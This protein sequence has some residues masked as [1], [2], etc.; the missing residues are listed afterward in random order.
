MRLHVGALAITLALL[1]GCATTVE[2]VAE[3]PSGREQ[4][5]LIER[6]AVVAALDQDRRLVAL[7]S[8]DG[9]I[10]VI[11]VAEEFRDFEKLHVGDVVMVSY[12]EAIAW[13][14]KASDSGAPGTSSREAL[15]NPKPGEAPG[16]ALERSITITATITGFD[17]T[18]G[19]VT[20][21]GPRGTSQTIKVR[22]PTDLERVRIGDL[23]EI[24][25]SEVRALAVRPVGRPR[26]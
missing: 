16:G 10:T 8:D 18:H 7:K 25:Y 9:T 15:T 13:Q 12:S 17:P 5:T 19:T 2:Q 3:R 6:R 11:P 1:A 23:V 20:L 22:T 26:P 21:T 24:T 4:T 14:V